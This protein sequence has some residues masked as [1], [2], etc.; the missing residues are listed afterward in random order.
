[1][2]KGRSKVT[3]KLQVTVP[4]A[5]ADE[6]GIKPGDEIEWT[7]SGRTVMVTPSISVPTLSVEERLAILDAQEERFRQ[8]W[9]GKKIPPA[10]AK[11]DWTREELYGDR[12]VPRHR[13]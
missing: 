8:R 7:A 3:S 10:P 1:M 4:K 6:A 12:G 9:A 2:T 5:I 13:R 11:R